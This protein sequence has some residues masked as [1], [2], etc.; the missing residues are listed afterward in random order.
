VEHSDQSFELRTTDI[1]DK[2]I[3]YAITAFEC[4][5]DLFHTILIHFWDPGYEKYGD[6]EGWPADI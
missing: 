5:G 3:G 2:G 1:V 4:G 6:R